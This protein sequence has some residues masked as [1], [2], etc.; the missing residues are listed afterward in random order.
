MSA[1]GSC[2]LILAVILGLGAAPAI[3]Q[4]QVKPRLQV[5]VDTSGSMVWTPQ[6]NTTFT[7]GVY[8]HGDGSNENPGCDVNGDGQFN[9]SKIYQAKQALANVV[10]AWGEVEWA[11]ERY[12]QATAGQTCSPDVEIQCASNSDCPTG[13]GYS[14]W[15]GYCRKSCNSGADCGSTGIYGCYTAGAHCVNCT[16]DAHCMPPQKCDLT[17]TQRY[18]CRQP[19][20]VNSDCP[21]NRCV[22]DG[23][24]SWCASCQSNSDCTAPYTCN[25]ATGQCRRACATDTDCAD[26]G[27]ENHMRCNGGTCAPDTNEYATWACVKTGNGQRVMNCPSPCS[28]ES[29]VQ[30][31]SSFAC[32]T[33]ACGWGGTVSDCQA[34]D[35]NAAN[36]VDKTCDGDALGTPFSATVRCAAP[37]DNELTPQACV[38]YSGYDAAF[39]CLSQWCSVGSDCPSGTCSAGECVCTSNAQCT[40]SGMSCVYDPS[41]G[42]GRCRSTGSG[43]ILVPFPTTANPENVSQILGW[44]DHHEYD[45]LGGT[46]RELRASGLT[47]IE[48]SLRTARDNLL[49]QVLP[50]D[51]AK[52]RCRSYDI[53]LLTDGAETCGGYAPYRAD[54]LYNH[55]RCGSTGCCCDA[56]PNTPGPN[57]HPGCVGATTCNPTTYPDQIRVKVYVIGFA[58]GNATSLTSLNDIAAAGGTTVAYT[59]ANQTQLEGALSEIV[60]N[61][62]PVERCNGSDDDCDGVADEPWPEKNTVT[63]CTV[64]VGACQKTGYYICTPPSQDPSR[65]TTCCGSGDRNGGG[66]CLSPGT[67]GTEI[68]DGLDNNCNGRTDEGA[69]WANKGQPCSVGTGACLRNGVYVCD[70]ANRGGATCCGDWS[71]GT[72]LSAGTPAPSETCNGIDDN[73][74]GQTDENPTDANQPC[75]TIP[76]NPG[77]PPTGKSWVCRAGT[78]VC[79]SPNLVCQNEVGPQTE[80]CDGS[81]NNCNGQVDEYWPEKGLACSVGVGTCMR[82]G[83]YICNPADNTRTCCGDAGTG[84]CLT[85]GTPGTERCNGLDDNCNGQVD[86]SDPAG[87]GT[88]CTTLPGNTGLGVCKKGV[89]ICQ[90]SPGGGASLIC[91][92]EVGPGPLVCNGLDNNCD[93][94]VDSN[95]W[96]NDPQVGHSC[97]YPAAGQCHPGQWACQGGTLTC[98]GGVGPTAEKCNGLDDDCDGQTDEDFPLKGSACTNG[99]GRCQDAGVF[100]CTADGSGVVCN[101][102]AGTPA[103]EV[104]NGVDDNCN[105]LIDEHPTTDEGGPCYTAPDGTPLGAGCDLG[106]GACLGACRLGALVCE[107]PHLVCEGAVGPQPEKCD[108][109]DN[110]CDGQTDEPFY[111]LGLGQA[112]DNGELGA[113][114]KTG[115]MVCNHAGDGVVCDA[116]AGVP[117]PEVCNGRDD[118]CNGE[119]DEGLSQEG[120]PCGSTVGECRPGTWHCAGAVGWECSSGSLPQPEVCDGKDNDCNGLIDDNPVDSGQPCYTA[121]DGSAFPRGCDPGTGAC[122]GTCQLGHMACESGALVCEDAVGPATEQCNGLD[123]DCDGVIDNDAACPPAMVCWQA[124][125]RAHCKPDEFPCPGG[126]TCFDLSNL[127]G[128]AGGV[129]CASPGDPNCFCVPS[130]CAGKTCPSGQHCDEGSGD[131]IDP[132]A[133]AHCQAWEVCQNGYCYDCNTVGCPAGERCVGN[134]CQQDPCFGVHCHD[135]QFCNDQGQ[136]QDLCNAG[137]CGQCQKCG[138]TGTC[139]PD[140]C[141]GKLCAEG[142]FCDP[143]DGACKDDPCSTVNCPAG[144]VCDKVDAQCVADPCAQISCSDCQQCHRDVTV[145]PPTAQCVQSTDPSCQHPTTWVTA[146]GG[147]CQAAGGGP[148][149]W[150]GLLLV[151]GGLAALGRALRRG[152]RR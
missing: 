49:T 22:A 152:G 80:V 9:D 61:S 72:C 15:N 126:Q 70:P 128:S 20:T 42:G 127:D 46:D 4:T 92:G 37:N 93:G 3:A 47:P 112:C 52:R 150:P 136:C 84:T 27:L 120:R 34:Y 119:T 125:C 121:P 104:C 135:G 106:A 10:S 33:S 142:Q 99:V 100:V 134:Q 116:A 118:N 110:D 30:C 95:D 88:A 82:T 85:A 94:H 59:V 123:D 138:P 83:V 102:V 79:Q 89:W 54:D 29:Y 113:C 45:F 91:F 62:I 87:L 66:T 57:A 101:A 14:C 143:A 25:T 50:N 69:L 31:S 74:N 13:F 73:C 17:G 65:L 129:P 26:S 38:Y 64:G 51:A 108:G 86:E 21:S 56:D 105:G 122:V 68:C 148:P 139:V 115:Q 151:L 146:Q 97:G 71:T 140:P 132:C 81:D 48:G 77:N 44:V 147:G 76:G 16:S 75:T 23:T 63:Q 58:I 130:K 28:E 137:S 18:T 141:C 55:L 67:P 109:V 12:A 145:S 35:G 7:Q 96:Q 19:C 53:V 98:Q 24:Q 60:A 11:L 32:G 107:S 2:H 40:T 41:A 131:C 8:T 124:E 90:P 1:R 149:P 133:Q 78:T 36:D 6:T 114:F 43:Q 103:P 117:M 39:V 144:F 5:I 111:A